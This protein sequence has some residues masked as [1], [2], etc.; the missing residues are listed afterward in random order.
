MR[1]VNVVLVS[2]L[3]LESL[4]LDLADLAEEV[5]DDMV[6]GVGSW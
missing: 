2:W 4:D 1:G 5:W 6:D 3:D